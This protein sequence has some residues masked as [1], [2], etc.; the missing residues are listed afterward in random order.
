MRRFNGIYGA[1]IAA[2][3]LGDNEKAP[4]YFEQLLELTENSNVERPEIKE[5]RKFIGQEAI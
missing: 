3:Q 1:A 2:K 5:A 4:L